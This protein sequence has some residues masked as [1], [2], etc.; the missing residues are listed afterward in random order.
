LLGNDELDTAP[1]V[2][3]TSEERLVAE[4]NRKILLRLVEQLE[5]LRRAV[6]VAYEL[7]GVSMAEVAASFSIPVNT[8][9]NRLRLG[10]EDLRAAWSR[11]V[12]TS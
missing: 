5:P 10:R 1:G 8:A 3:P 4:E 11:W 6:V 7:E 12:K 9:W 2:G